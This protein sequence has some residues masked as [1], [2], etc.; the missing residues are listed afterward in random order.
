M[1]KLPST[2]RPPTALI[3]ED[4]GRFREFLADVLREMEYA[5]VGASNAEEGLRLARESAPDLVLLDLNLPVV[6]GIGFLEEFR[7]THP[8]T[9]VVI[10]TGFGDLGAAKDAIRL[11]VSDF[12]TKPCD[13]G[14][15]ERAI[16]KAAG[17][18]TVATREDSEEALVNVIAGE[19]VFVPLEARERE[20]VVEALRRSGGNRTEAARLLGIS[21][22]ALYNKMAAY[23]EEGVELP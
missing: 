11:G 7:R 15:I 16:S 9:P 12:L 2:P 8:K 4:E 10:I 6:D 22:R 14:Q 20:A 13:L 3:V 18:R 1:H 19:G 21:R 5:P 17:R 23:R